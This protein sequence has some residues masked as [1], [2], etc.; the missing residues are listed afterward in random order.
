MMNNTITD[1]QAEIKLKHIYQSMTKEEGLATTLSE[2]LGFLV[3]TK[4]GHA[5]A[6][7]FTQ[8]ELIVK[9][10]KV[11]KKKDVLEYD[12]DKEVEEIQEI[13]KELHPDE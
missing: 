11:L 1:A 7:P 4:D 10:R 2:L 3:A 9:A 8:D 5:E 13:Q 6:Y 12:I